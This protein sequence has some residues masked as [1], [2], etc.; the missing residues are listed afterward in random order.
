MISLYSVG[1][2]EYFVAYK[3]GLT[4]KAYSLG[5]CVALCLLHRDGGVY[6]MAHVV[7]SDSIALP[8]QAK[9]LPC[10]FADT[11]LP[12]LLEK[13]MPNVHPEQVADKGVVAKLVGGA[14]VL[15]NTGTGDIGKRSID[16]LKFLLTNYRIPII[17]SDVG[18]SIPRSVVLNSDNGDV[19]VSSVGR[20]D[21]LL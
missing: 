14:K 6:G 4:I 11:A 16:A 13:I 2:G 8:S 20:E 1:L 9:K 3:P 17:A 7:M 19:I 15:K 18:G 10:Y 21:R 12:F 5:S